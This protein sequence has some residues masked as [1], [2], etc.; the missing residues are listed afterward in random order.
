V[1]GRFLFRWRGIIGVIAFGV[2]FWLAVP[3]FGSC[4]LG[5]PL[6]LVG[7]ATRFWASGYIGIEGRVRE[8]GGQRE[9]RGVTSE[10]EATPHRRIVTGPYR[11]LRHP[12]YIGNF[13]LVLGM[14]AAL[15]PAAWLGVVVVVG[16]VVEY[17]MII[18]AEEKDLAPEG[19]SGEGVKG[20]CGELREAGGE[21]FSARRALVEWQ[22]WAV[23]AVG[24]GLSLLKAFIIG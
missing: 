20:S 8:I 14:L 3:T 13:M 9:K 6:L 17:T 19:S 4:L 18:A 23:T 5:I 21:S 24:W 10:G 22:T 16:F 1:L 2:V 12:L 15:R 11:L 7:L